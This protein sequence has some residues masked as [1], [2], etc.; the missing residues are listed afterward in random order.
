MLHVCAWC[1]VRLIAT[2]AQDPRPSPQGATATSHSICPLCAAS[3]LADL[4][5]SVNDSG[6]GKALGAPD[7]QCRKVS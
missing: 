7:S 6:L 1:G 5:Q 2:V 4:E 3:M